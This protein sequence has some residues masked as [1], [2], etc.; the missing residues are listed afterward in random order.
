MY[1]KI[2]FW[3]TPKVKKAMTVIVVIT[4]LLTF[5]DFV[6][7]WKIYPFI[8]NKILVLFNF[9]LNNT[10]EAFAS[11]I[12][13]A[14]TLFLYLLYRRVIDSK[15]DALELRISSLEQKLPTTLTQAMTHTEEKI[16]ASESTLS[17]RIFNI[18]WSMID[19]E[20]EDHKRKNQIGAMSCLI[21]KLKMA[22]KRG[23][24]I[25]DVLFEMREYIKEHSMPSVYFEDLCKE[26]KRCSEDL[27]ILK[28]EI[29]TLA[30]EKLYKV[31]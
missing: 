27:D 30:Q 31:G 6:Q 7:K 17:D 24:G 2:L 18:E 15:P 1:K 19:G 8:Y 14:L 25:E 13:F 29:I 3:C 16:K 11:I 10:F 12:L 28:N 9:V 5:F 4:T 20:I 23:W 26:L 21:K 22:R